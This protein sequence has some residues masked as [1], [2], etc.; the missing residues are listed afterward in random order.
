MVW[1]KSDAGKAGSRDMASIS[2]LR[3]ADALSRTE[4]QQQVHKPRTGRMIFDQLL[5]NNITVQRF[6]T[7][8]C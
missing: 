3:Q 7:D 1:N 4:N 5:S 6:H 2:V 8:R